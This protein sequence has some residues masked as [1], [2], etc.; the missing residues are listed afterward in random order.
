MGGFFAIRRPQRPDVDDE[1]PDQDEEDKNYEPY[2]FPKRVKVDGIPVD[3]MRG[4]KLA[5]YFSDMF[6]PVTACKFQSK[7]SV[8]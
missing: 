3:Y 6:G 1:V 2:K 8:Y 7:Q 5:D 4:H